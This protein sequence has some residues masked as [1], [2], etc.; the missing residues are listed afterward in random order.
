MWSVVETVSSLSAQP[1]WFLFILILG[2]GIVA[3]F[4]ATD[5]DSGAGDADIRR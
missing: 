4:D 5:D 2:E 3:A 1:A